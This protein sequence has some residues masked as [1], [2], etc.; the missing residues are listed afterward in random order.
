MKAV[1]C[2]ICWF[3]DLTT[4]NKNIFSFLGKADQ[5]LL[6]F[7][8]LFINIIEYTQFPMVELNKKVKIFTKKSIL[9]YEHV[10]TSPL[11]YLP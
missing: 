4:K 1:N 6:K 11:T 5:K 3:E 8:S 2:K 9:I 7:S 10:M